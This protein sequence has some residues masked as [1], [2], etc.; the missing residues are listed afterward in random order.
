MGLDLTERKFYKKA[1]KKG[2]PWDLSKGIDGYFPISEFIEFDKIKDLNNIELL[3]KINY[4]IF[5][6]ENMKKMYF[7]IPK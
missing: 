6:N 5:L 7:K 1:K 2:F 3:L 4:K